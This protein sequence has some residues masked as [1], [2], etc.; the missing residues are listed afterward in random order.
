MVKGLSFASGKCPKWKLALALIIL[1]QIFTLP[2]C[3]SIDST[4]PQNVQDFRWPTLVD[5]TRVDS[6]LWYPQDLPYDG[7]FR[8]GYL[9][10][11][12]PEIVLYFTRP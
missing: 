8:V 11:L 1:I 6:I 5:T 9:G 4:E 10:E 12:R 3:D 2:A 7:G